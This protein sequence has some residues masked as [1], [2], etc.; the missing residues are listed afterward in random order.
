MRVLD[1]LCARVTIGTTPGHFR[2]LQRNWHVKKLAWVVGGDG[3]HM[4]LREGPVRGMLKLGFEP[5]WVI[6]RAEAGF[7]FKLA[8]FPASAVQA[9]P[10]TWEGVFECIRLHYPAE[11]AECVLPFAKQLASRPYHEIEEEAMDGFLD[12]MSFY[13]VNMLGKNGECDDHRF[14]NEERLLAAKAAGTLTIGH[15]RGFLYNMV[16]LS[17]LFDGC[18]WT[19]EGSTGRRVV[20]EYLCRGDSPVD[21]I[22]C[23]RYFQLSFDLDD[24]HQLAADSD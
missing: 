24:L 9:Q 14:M 17:P 2:C 18:G 15:A 13:D 4:L 7:S 19:K 20:K 10:A 1:R 16:G 6:A 21:T 12:G 8:V 22:P 3:L 5:R 23:F 11:V